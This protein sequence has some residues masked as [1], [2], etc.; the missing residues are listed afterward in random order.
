MLRITTLLIA[1]FLYAQISLAQSSDYTLRETDFVPFPLSQTTSDVITGV[2]ESSGGQLKIVKLS[3]NSIDDRN[4]FIIYFSKGAKDDNEILGF[5]FESNDNA[6]L[7]VM[8]WDEY[9]DMK[10]IDLGV[11]LS[12]QDD[13]EDSS[14]DS[15]EAYPSECREAMYMIQIKGVSYIRKVCTILE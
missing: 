12:S 1:L 5:A 10:L 13:E 14:L 8:Y 6:G 11:Y 7:T 4:W 15:E 2:W 9:G 3:S